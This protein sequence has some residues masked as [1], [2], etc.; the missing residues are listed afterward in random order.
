MKIDGNDIMLYEDTIKHLDQVPQSQIIDYLE[1]TSKISLF[2]LKPTIVAIPTIYST[3]Q[4]ILQD[5]LVMKV[6][7][8]T[9]K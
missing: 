2:K 9:F 5:L 7:E 8:A 6:N 3:H 4:K 1:K